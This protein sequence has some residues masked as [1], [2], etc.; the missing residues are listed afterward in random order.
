MGGAFSPRHRPSGNRF[1]EAFV[2]LV[3]ILGL[4]GAGVITYQ[5]NEIKHLKAS[6]CGVK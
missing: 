5:A 2:L 3:M 1:L 4:V 6:N